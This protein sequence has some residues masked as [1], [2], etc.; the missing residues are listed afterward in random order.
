V[1][2]YYR[3]VSQ[4][5]TNNCDFQNRVTSSRKCWKSELLDMRRKGSDTR[6]RYY[7]RFQRSDF[8]FWKDMLFLVAWNEDVHMRECRFLLPIFESRKTS[9]KIVFVDTIH[10]CN[11]REEP[12]LQPGSTRTHKTAVRVPVSAQSMLVLI[13]DRTI[14][15]RT[16]ILGVCDEIW[17]FFFVD[18]FSFLYLWP[19]HF[20][21]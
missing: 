4:R 13:D 18:F 17:D 3:P 8:V 21:Q 10:E 19:Y 6:C 14:K 20:T 12:P 9:I 7:V 1:D 11:A 2:W 16:T 15:T 5:T